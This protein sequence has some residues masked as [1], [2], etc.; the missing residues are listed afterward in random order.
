MVQTLQGEQQ[1]K[2]ANQVLPVLSARLRI[3]PV[4]DAED[5]LEALAASFLRSVWTKPSSPKTAS[6]ATIALVASLGKVVRIPGIAV[7]WME[8]RPSSP[9]RDASFGT[10][11]TDLYALV[12]SNHL[13]PSLSRVLLRSLFTQLNEDALPFLASTYAT[14][15]LS[16]ALRIVAL[17]HATAFVSA[18]ASS[19]EGKAVDFQMVLPS[20]LV[21]MQDSNQ[22]VR[23]AGV[24]VLKAIGGL[25]RIGTGEIF[26]LDT[27]YGSQ[28]RK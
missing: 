2:L 24:G 14:P 26:A 11:S 5:A 12:N 13:P 23:E 16:S 4:R 21:A 6:R 15:S 25:I 3:A 28:S 27:F 20:L 22:D 18:H 9:S 7:D 1:L 10:F 8:E 19:E 17:R